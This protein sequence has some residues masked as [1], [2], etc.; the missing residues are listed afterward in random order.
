MLTPD[1]VQPTV[2]ATDS[3]GLSTGRFFVN[4]ELH[5]EI[6]MEGSEDVVTLDLHELGPGP[7]EIV[8]EVVDAVE[9]LGRIQETYQSPE[10]LAA[11]VILSSEIRTSLDS[12]DGGALTSIAGFTVQTSAIVYVPRGDNP[13]KANDGC[14][15]RVLLENVSGFQLDDFAVTVNA[16]DAI[17]SC[18]PSGRTRSL[19]WANASRRDRRYSVDAVPVM[20]RMRTSAP[21]SVSARRFRC[22][23]SC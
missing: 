1:G 9:D 14:E 2:Y 15:H 20:A 21:A 11:R 10:Y 23:F 8:A 19:M 4:G 12:I 3:S 17:D 6:D 18:L 5:T 13:A 16:Y 7:H 22:S